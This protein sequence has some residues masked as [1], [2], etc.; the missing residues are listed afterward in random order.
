MPLPVRFRIAQLGNNYERCGLRLKTISKSTNSSITMM[1]TRFCPKS[2]Q[3]AGISFGMSNSP[4][5]Q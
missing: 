1:F 5:I 2:G 4:A 3:N